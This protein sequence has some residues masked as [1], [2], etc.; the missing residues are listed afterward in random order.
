LWGGDKTISHLRQ[1]P[2]KTRAVELSF[3][4]RFSFCVLKAQAVLGEAEDS[5]RKFVHNFFNDSFWFDQMACSSPRMVVWIGTEEEIAAAKSRFWPALESYIGEKGL[6]YP[7]VVGIT[8]MTAMY[9]YAAQGVVDK[10]DSDPTGFPAR[11]HLNSTSGEFRE[12]HCGGGLFLEREFENLHGVLQFAQRKDQTMSA[13]GFSRSEIET[14][15]RDLPNGAIDR[16]V[17]VGKSLAFS[18]V[19]DGIDLLRA[20]SR[21]VEID[22]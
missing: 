1:I 21:Y 19:W 20:F 14:F 8:R 3:A 17:A 4:D 12:E 6:E 15:A 10:V 11:A 7:A 9:A 22:L 5:L 13:F 2:S 18:P 16:I